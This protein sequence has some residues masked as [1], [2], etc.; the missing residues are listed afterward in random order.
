MISR[1]ALSP[2]FRQGLTMNS[3]PQQTQSSP[4]WQDQAVE[5][6]R[7][8]ADIQTASGLLALQ[9]LN[10]RARLSHQMQEAEERGVAAQLGWDVPER[11]PE[12]ETDDVIHLGDSKVE[13]HH[14][15]AQGETGDSARNKIMKT[16]L[17]AA[18]GAAVP[19]AGIVGHMLADKAV[20]AAAPKIDQ[21]IDKTVDIGLLR[22]EDLSPVD[23][24]SGN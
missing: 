18:I 3:D 9:S 11:T 4:K 2:R 19:G 12:E 21:V 17:A 14:H 20:D 22:E 15:P 6:M 23:I 13:H 24:P 8:R 10:R 5:V 1:P 7:D 16:V